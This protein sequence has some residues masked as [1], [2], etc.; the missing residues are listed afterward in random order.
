VLDQNP[1]VPLFFGGLAGS[2]RQSA[3]NLKVDV[4]T[5]E[6]RLVSNGDRTLNWT[7][8]AYRKNDRRLQDRSG[9]TISVPALGIA[10]DQ[11][12]TSAQ[13]RSKA[14]AIFGDL[15]YKF[16]DALA[17]QAGVRRYES[18]DSQV[19]TIDTTSAIFGTTAG[20]TRPSSGRSSATS[21]KL[22]LSWKPSK[23]LLVFAK[24]ADGFRN[25]GS[26]FVVPTEPTMVPSY[27]PEKVRAYEL[28]LKSQPSPDWT[29]NASLYVNRWSD[30]QLSFLTP[31]ALYSFIQNAGRA[32]STGGE[33]EVSARP[34][35]GLRLGLAIGLV[36]STI[37]QDVFNALGQKIAAK[38]N[39]IPNSPR[40]QAAA[41]VAYEFTAFGGLG[42]A[43]S[44]N[45]SHRGATFSDPDNFAETRN[46]SSNNLYLRL[47]LN[48][49]TWGAA[50]FVSNATN[51][52]ATLSRQRYVGS[53]QAFGTHVQPR[54][55]GVEFSAQF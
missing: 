35:Q 28:G 46:D 9:F 36:D 6:V 18:K 44:A 29:I 33:V 45:L 4:T 48:G 7:V 49:D 26:N 16:G 2:A 37:D 12:F 40:V 54:T 14:N 32:K 43:V 10:G 3:R 42:G 47:G 25:G 19:I 17:L 55:V 21:P 5:T 38:G 53:T 23:D 34:V 27:G 13:A 15:E 51:D 20:D 41:S 11:S 22:G 30:L 8:G 50:L 52:K 1:V 39:R 24:V 31:S